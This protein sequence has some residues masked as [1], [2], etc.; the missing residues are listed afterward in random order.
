MM[1]DFLSFSAFQLSVSVCTLLQGHSQVR[2]QVCELSFL[3]LAPQA[4]DS[5]SYWFRIWWE[6]RPWSCD[7]NICHSYVSQSLAVGL[8]KI[9]FCK[10]THCWHFWDMTASSSHNSYG[11]PDVYSKCIF[12][13]QRIS[14]A[15]ASQG[16]NVQ[17]WMRVRQK[18]GGRADSGGWV[19]DRAVPSCDQISVG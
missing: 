2:D 16:S 15:W 11:P 3:L 7:I 17:E 8:K 5:S 6:V 10:R 13:Y 14:H 18:E 4:V 1:F 12:F 9:P 19:G